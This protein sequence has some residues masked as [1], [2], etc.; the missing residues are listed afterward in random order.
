ME[1][2]KPRSQFARQLEA[3]RIQFEHG[4]KNGLVMALWACARLQKPM[5]RWVADAWIRGWWDTANGVT[6][7]NSVLGNVRVK[8]AKKIAREKRDAARLHKL[9]KLLPSVRTP[10]ERDSGG[11]FQELAEKMKLP[12]RTVRELYYMKVRIDGKSVRALDPEFFG[13]RSLG[14]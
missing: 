12:A 11:A 14:K 8:T 1:A 13:R 4:D 3:F 5:P 6:D 7:W 10:I 9:A 2:G